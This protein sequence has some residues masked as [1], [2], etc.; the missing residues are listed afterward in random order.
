MEL[1]PLNV[2]GIILLF[3]GGVFALWAQPLN[4]RF[5]HFDERHEWT[6]RWKTKRIERLRRWESNPTKYWF[7]PVVVGFL[8]FLGWLALVFAEGRRIPGPV[9]GVLSGGLITYG[10]VRREGSNLS[11][12]SNRQRV[13]VWIMRA[14]GLLMMS[15]GVILL[16]L[17]FD[18][19]D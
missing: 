13:M 19:L 5:E 9:I 18:V 10:I 3:I 16:L 2:L 15:M 1:N 17:G 12:E 4:E 7:I 11:E 6:R 8:I 14:S